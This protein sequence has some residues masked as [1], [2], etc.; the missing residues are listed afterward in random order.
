[1]IIEHESCKTSKMFGK[2]GQEQ[3]Q[4]HNLK[5]HTY[6]ACRPGKE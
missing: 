6:G 4:Q 3:E 5:Q 2:E 1:M